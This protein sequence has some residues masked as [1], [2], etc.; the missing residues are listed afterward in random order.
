MSNC[1][2]VAPNVELRGELTVIEN[3][4]ITLTCDYADVW[5][6]GNQSSFHFRE[7]PVVQNK[8]RLFAVPLDLYQR[9]AARF[10]L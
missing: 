8:V 4:G 3:D 6:I 1:L 2:H 10:L 7:V 5:P 9:F